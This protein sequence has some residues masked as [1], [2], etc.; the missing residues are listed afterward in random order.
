MIYLRILLLLVISNYVD[1]AIVIPTNAIWKYLDNGT[2]QGS[3]WKNVSFNDAAWL[4]GAA[5]LGYGDA[6]V[7]PLTPNLITYYFRRSINISNPSQYVDF[8]INL[9]RD[10]GIVLY[11]NGS[12]VYRNNMPTGT[13]A[14]NTLASSACADDG[15]AIFSV[16]IPTSYFTNG[17]NVIAAE[18][19][20]S[21][22]SSSDIT[23]EL[24]L[25]SNTL[26]TII[27][28]PYIQST[29]TNSAI[30]KWQ[31]SVACDTKVQWGPTLSYGNTLQS[32]AMV[33]HHEIQLNGLTPNSKHYYTIET[34]TDLLQGNA[35][36]FIYP[37]PTSG[38][39]NIWAIG[40]FGN[41]STSQQAVL[42][43]YLNYLGSNRNDV[44]LWLGDNAYESGSDAEYQ[45]NVFNI[46]G[47]QFKSWN[48]YPALGNHD[49]ANVGYKSNEALSTNF[50]YFAIFSLPTAAENGG[51]A[52]NTEKYYSYDISNIHFINLDSYGSYNE[53][54]SAMYNWLQNDLINNSQK[55]TIAY[56][57]HPPY[58]KGS[59][60]SDIEQEL[61]DMRKHIIPL[62][63]SYGVDLVLSGHS[64][65]YE[66]SYF[67]HGHYG[68]EN[69]FDSSMIV[70]GGD[71]MSNPY[72]KDALHNGTV[73]A[74]CGVSGKSSTSVASGYPHNAM[75]N[76]LVGLYGS[77]VLE[78]NQDTLS[79][80]FLKSDGTIPDQFRIIKTL[81]TSMVSVNLNLML[82]GY[83]QGNS[84]MTPVLNNQQVGVNL[85]VVDTIQ[86][87]LYNS[88]APYSLIASSKA[89]LLTNGNAIATFP[90]GVLGNAY[91]VGVKQRSS[92]ETWS[93]SPIVINSHLVNYNFTTLV[94]QAYGNN[95]VEV[96][97]NIF[98]FYSGD[99]NQDGAIDA[100]DYM[101]LDPDVITGAFGYLSTDLSGDG[102]VDAFDYLI[103]DLNLTNGVGVITP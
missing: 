43:S 82:Q 84:I 42:N 22:A 28:G 18:V 40:D 91:Y 80:K 25:L 45:S 99:I 30:L 46:Y 75:M 69:T 98:A 65:N 33:T 79:Y 17:N 14:Y 95:Q 59:H 64:H 34:S 6:P 11:V 50:P 3:A 16:N 66:R 87:L 90:A 85:N 97:P 36:N 81:P 73:Y 67:M 63:E 19:H 100:F 39:V 58:S 44:W 56:F 8:T 68:V 24:E 38:K 20:N 21:A 101:L 62:L 53:P 89:L 32:S 49:Y 88:F 103:L 29:T 13:I 7:T 15:N 93:A 72:I 96:E 83:Y 94:S 77:I 70:Q 74:V 10:D 27:R 55:W 86:V 92:I 5:E 2:N 9:R 23:F 51:V 61:I 1:A 102:V 78:I 60:D 57:H 31:T 35:S 37:I 26:P 41:G 71:G 4:S 52:S 54:G 12:E 47:H 48:F 76:S